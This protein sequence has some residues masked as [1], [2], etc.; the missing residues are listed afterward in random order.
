MPSEA[1][2]SKEGWFERKREEAFIKSSIGRA[3]SKVLFSNHG[4]VSYSKHYKKGTLRLPCWLNW[5]FKKKKM[6]NSKA[7]ILWFE[8]HACTW[9]GEEEIG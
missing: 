3:S 5:R 9:T 4:Y 2:G 6:L 1:L 7:L 8:G